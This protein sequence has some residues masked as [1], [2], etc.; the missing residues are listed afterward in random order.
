MVT[1]KQAMSLCRLRD[2]ELVSLIRDGQTRYDAVWFSGRKIR[3]VFD[4]R[5]VYVVHIDAD[6]SFDG[7]YE[8]FLFTVRNIS[9]DELRKLFYAEK[10]LK[11]CS[12]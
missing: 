11:T 10:R 5:R 8:G 4:M 9:V 3:E 7:T 1:L 6:F 2:D 12:L